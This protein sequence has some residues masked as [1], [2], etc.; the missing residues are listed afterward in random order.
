MDAHGTDLPGTFSHND[1]ESAIETSAGV[2]SGTNVI[3]TSDDGVNWVQR[4]SGQNTRAWDH[5]I[6]YGNGFFVVPINGGTL[7]STDGTN[8]VQHKSESIDYAAGIAHGNGQFVAVGNKILMSTDGVSWVERFSGLGFNMPLAGIAYGNGM[9]VAVGPQVVAVDNSVAGRHITVSSTDAVNWVL[10]EWR[11]DGVEYGGSEFLNGIAY[12]NGQFVV[13]GGGEDDPPSILTSTDGVNW[14]PRSTR[15]RDG[16]F[17]QMLH[18][19][20]YG[21][22]HFVAT[23]DRWMILQSGSIITLSITPNIGTGLLTLSLEGPTGLDYTIQSSSDLISWRDVTKITSAQSN[24][25]ILDGLPAT[26]E[27]AFFRAYSQSAAD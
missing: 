27:R 21:N 5:A 23:G 20:G 7:T 1:I 26:P 8:W 12:G 24:K 22:G 18:G 19:I 25:V 16:G 9:F 15:V 4:F 6:A 2:Y 13:V 17:N 11:I 3:V 10:H 14:V